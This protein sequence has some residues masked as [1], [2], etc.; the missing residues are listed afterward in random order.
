MALTLR[1]G[2]LEMLRTCWRLQARHVKIPILNQMGLLCPA[3]ARHRSSQSKL[4][5][6]SYVPPT[7]LS[8]P[9]WP[10]V[11]YISSDEE[12]RQHKVV[13]ENVN[14]LLAKEDYGRLFAV[15]HFASRQWKVTNEDLIL[16]ENHIDAE[17]GDKIR[18]EKVLL[19]GGEE[20]TLIGRPLL[21]RDLVRVEA[22]VIEKTESWPKVHMRFW[23][24]HRYQKKRI[25]VQP[26]TVLRINT[27]EVA[28][29][30]T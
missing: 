17:C 22:T 24:R 21:G 9:L 15:V 6:S 29:R 27:I 3:I 5:S 11:S 25:I 19:V 12:E 20:F 16:I 13:L 30:L 2:Y 1:N 14:T 18:L 10:E 7:S 28:P 23:K 8:R 4:P 26:Q